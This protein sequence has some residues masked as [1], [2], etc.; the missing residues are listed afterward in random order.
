[1]ATP[2]TSRWEG[3]MGKSGWAQAFELLMAEY[4]H[5]YTFFIGGGGEGG[6]GHCAVPMSSPYTCTC[7]TAE[8]RKESRRLE[9]EIDMKLVSFSKLGSTYS[10][11]DVSDGALGIGGSGHV[12]DTMA[13]EIEQLLSKVGWPLEA[14]Q[15]YTHLHYGHRKV[16]VVLLCWAITTFPGYLTKRVLVWEW[17]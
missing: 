3:E 5:W 11:R 2:R 7:L 15:A 9:N 13:L 10:H 8:L 6:G 17:G 12:F 16:I 1:M 4:Y 14:T